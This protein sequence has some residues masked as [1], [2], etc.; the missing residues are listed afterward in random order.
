MTEAIDLAHRC[1]ARPL[2][3]YAQDELAA[4]GYRRRRRMLLRG[5][6]SLTPSEQRIARMAAD[7]MSNAEIAQALFLSRKTIE[8]HL[9]HAYE[10][11]GVR[12][13]TELPGALSE[14]GTPVA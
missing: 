7:G 10:K 11:L 14:P 3:D 13:R 4:S 6:D 1:G 8:M 12:S 9:A 2:V 5:V